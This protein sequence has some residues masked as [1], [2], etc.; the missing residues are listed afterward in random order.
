M[1]LELQKLLVR[2][3]DFHILK[4]FSLVLV[5]LL[6]FATFLAK[7][8]LSPFQP[9]CQNSWKGLSDILFY[10]LRFTDGSEMVRVSEWHGWQGGMEIFLLTK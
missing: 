2:V 8:A 7:D 3:K 5:D 9:R 10:G 1:S 4:R 6:V